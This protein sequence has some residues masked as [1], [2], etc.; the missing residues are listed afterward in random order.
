MDM[1][2]L[3]VEMQIAFGFTVHSVER[4]SAIGYQ[5]VVFFNLCNRMYMCIL[6]NVIYRYML[7]FSEI[8]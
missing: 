6:F 3:P 1:I 7:I 8:L 2:G 4:G 5:I